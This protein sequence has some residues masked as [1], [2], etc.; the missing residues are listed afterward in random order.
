MKK[1]LPVL[2][3]SFLLAACGSDD[4]GNPAAAGGSGGLSGS[5]GVA[6]AETGGTAGS[7]G[8]AGCS[9]GPTTE[10]ILSASWQAL[11]A[12]PEIQG[13]QD[14]VYFVTPEYGLSVNGLGRIYR[15]MDGGGVFE[16]VL[17]QPGTYFRA[18]LMLDEEHGFV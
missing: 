11:P 14:D 2:L 9:V 18:V 12:A 6:G 7:A 16:E 4:S 13:K 15:T 5:G 10:Q 3:L 1:L 17:N 8:V